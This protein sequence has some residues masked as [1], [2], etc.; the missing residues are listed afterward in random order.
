MLRGRIF[1]TPGQSSFLREMRKFLF[2]VF[3]FAFHSRSF[4]QQF[5]QYNTGTLYDAFENPSQ[6]AFIPDS[7]RKIAT[8]F[9]VPNFGT[10]FTLSGNAQ[11]ALK[12]R[13]FIYSYNDDALTLGKGNFNY[14]RV[15]A[16]AYFLMFR[17]YSSLDGNQEIGLSG[18]TRFEGRTTFSDESALLLANNSKFIN[19]SYSDLFNYNYRYQIYHQ[20]GLTFRKDIDQQFAIGIK[21]SLLMGVVANQVNVYHS[22]I[23][24]DRQNDRAFIS[25]SGN[26]GSSFEPGMFSA[27]DILPSLRNPGASISTGISYLSDDHL[28]VQLNVKDLGF[29]HW[30]SQS[31]TGDFNNTGVLN[32]LR[33]GHFEDTVF[34]TAS[35]LV[36]ARDIQRSFNTNGLIEISG[37]RSYWLRNWGITYTPT[38]ILSKELFY[39]GF[40]GALVNHFRYHN[41]TLTLTGSYDDMKY[42]AVGAQFMVKSPNAE[43]FIGSDRLFQTANLLS[44]ANKSPQLGSI[45]TYTGGNIF[46]GFSVKI[47]PVIEHPSNS[48]LIPMGDN[49]SFL[50]R[51]WQR[52]TGYTN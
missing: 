46:L 38:A 25:V 23:N 6:R 14:A 43:F 3:L 19:N 2:I 11:A 47:G 1:L 51:L 27:H 18:Q 32:G 4:A 52:I 9:L 8:N 21:A 7:S 49:R 34:H 39:T 17:L 20:V 45:G 35:S 5:S 24:F 50:K 31:F 15:N 10:N 26:Y 22:I 29:I 37:S 30:S 41:Y 36:Q 33:T 40:T 13:A 12:S 42:T 48:H 28:K 16:N 44:A